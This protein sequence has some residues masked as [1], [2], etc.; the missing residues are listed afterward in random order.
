TGVAAR[1]VGGDPG[2]LLQDDDARPGTAPRDLP[3]DGQPDDARPDDAGDPL[4][5]ARHQAR[6][7]SSATSPATGGRGFGSGFAA[8]LSAMPGSPSLGTP[9]SDRRVGPSCS[10]ASPATT[11][12]GSPPPAARASR[13]AAKGAVGR[14]NA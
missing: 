5:H 8:T 10:P 13:D 11:A 6:S 1:L 7:R 4:G 3:P 12:A 9:R 14:L 2:F